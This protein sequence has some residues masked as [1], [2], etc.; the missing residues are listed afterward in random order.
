MKALA[1]IFAF[2]AGAFLG[3]MIVRAET[4]TP[5][6][7]RIAPSKSG[8]PSLEIVERAA[9]VR[10]GRPQVLL[11]HA[12]DVL[13]AAAFDVPGASLMQHLAS[14]GRTAWALDLSGFGLLERPLA[15][16]RPGDG[17]PFIASCLGGHGRRGSDEF[18]LSVPLARG[19]E[20][21]CS[22]GLGL[23]P[24]R[25]MGC[26][27]SAGFATSDPA[28]QQVWLQMA[29]DDGFCRSGRSECS[30]RILRRS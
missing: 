24:W 28:G 25:R 30:G 7:H 4:A 6:D 23:E 26:Q 11:L 2:V 8:K 16:E 18:P 29:R 9:K 21:I 20:A 13:S 14:T 27:E 3:G 22:D 15:M 1:R 19:L 17:S 5:V 12:Y 10:C